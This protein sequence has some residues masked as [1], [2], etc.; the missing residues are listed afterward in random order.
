M[1][2]SYVKFKLVSLTK[3]KGLIF[4]DAPQASDTKYTLF[5]EG[6]KP[7]T[8]KVAKT[9]SMPSVSLVELDLP[10]PFEFGKEHSIYLSNYTSEGAYEVDVKASGEDTKL[11]YEPKTTKVKV[12][13][14][15]K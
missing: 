11:V 7:V 12:I 10:A 4:S 8:L 9:A 15:K 2:N 13:I 14:R 1:K 3:V 6:E 5:K